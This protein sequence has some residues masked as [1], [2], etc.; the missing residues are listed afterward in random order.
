R[1]L[2]KDIN[3]RMGKKKVKDVKPR[4]IDSLLQA[5]LKRGA[6]SI[7]NDVLRWIRRIFDHAIKLGMIEVNPAA[8]FDMSD[9]G[10][11]ETSRER[12]LT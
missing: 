7:A 5:I 11:K 12:W 10:G 4:D 3:P 2:E 6:P 1:R 8:A 9:A